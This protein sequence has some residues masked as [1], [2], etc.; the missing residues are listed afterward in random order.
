VNSSATLWA[1]ILG[2]AVAQVV[3]AQRPAARIVSS[4][5][6]TIAAG[7]YYD[8]GPIS[9]FFFGNTYRDYWVK[10][11][12]VPVLNL[13]S[14]AGGLEPLKEGG[15]M[16]TLNLRL[17]AVDGSEFIFRLVNKVSANPGDASLYG[18]GEI[19]IPVS[20]IRHVVPID[21]GCSHSPMR[22]ECT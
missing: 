13:R 7:T 8:A 4:D 14:Y 21:L 1:G 10:P 22:A 15:G 20:R 3:N 12:R 16:Q 6:A 18:T 19:R 9:R 11:I 5:S 17:G 2:S